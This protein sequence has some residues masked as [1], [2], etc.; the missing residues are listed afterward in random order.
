M[1]F[2]SNSNEFAQGLRSVKLL[3]PPAA[4][5]LHLKHLKTGDRIGA[6]SVRTDSHEKPA[7]QTWL[8]PILARKELYGFQPNSHNSTGNNGK[9]H[10]K[11]FFKSCIYFLRL[12][13]SIYLITELCLFSIIY[14]SG[15]K[16]QTLM[17]IN[18]LINKRMH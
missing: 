14:M 11:L 8:C 4:G 17:N 10:L 7:K 9:P 18:K 2:Q 3:I 1:Q 12:K 15:D 6:F 13:L 5:F 16:K